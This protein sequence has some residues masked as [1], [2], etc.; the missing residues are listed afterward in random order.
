MNTR[1]TLNVYPIDTQERMCVCG[2]A[3][4]LLSF[5]V[6]L[7][8]F[9]VAAGRPLLYIFPH[10]DPLKFYE[11]SDYNFE[12]VK[13]TVNTGCGCVDTS[14]VRLVIAEE[15][16]RMTGAGSDGCCHGAASL[17]MS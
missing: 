8:V 14:G 17:I 3:R 9:F 1:N 5:D 7:G 16:R 11:R 13:L 15:S 12:P 6:D 2:P 10:P 4:A